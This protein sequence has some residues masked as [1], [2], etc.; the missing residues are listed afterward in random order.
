MTH[1]C[2]YCDNVIERSDTGAVR[3]HLSGL[4]GSSR[5]AAQ[6]MFAHSKCVAE[7]FAPNLSPSV[8][9]DVET[10]EPG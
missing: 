9:F 2:C 1:Q 7:R 5:D 8:P 4:W 6:D 10:F 3:I